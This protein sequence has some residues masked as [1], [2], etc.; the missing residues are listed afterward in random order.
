MIELN[1]DN[2]K[3]VDYLAL[4]FGSHGSGGDDWQ[5][6]NFEMYVYFIDA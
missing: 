5:F 3:I 2:Y 4:R 1:F 6:N